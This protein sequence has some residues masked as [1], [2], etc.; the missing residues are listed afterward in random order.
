[1]RRADEVVLSNRRLQYVRCALIGG[2]V[3][4]NPL[5]RPSEMFSR[6]AHSRKGMSNS[7]SS[8]ARGEIEFPLTRSE[9]LKTA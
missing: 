2:A 3:S 4:T 9:A 1:V 6:A 7:T 8:G 5:D